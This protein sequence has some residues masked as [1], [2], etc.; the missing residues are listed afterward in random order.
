MK[1][2]HILIPLLGLAMACS[3]KP[4]PNPI[5]EPEEVITPEAVYNFDTTAF[6][7]KEPFIHI[8]DSGLEGFLVIYGYDTDNQVNGK[9]SR[10]DVNTVSS[11]HLN[12]FLNHS[13]SILIEKHLYFTKRYELNQSGE[14]FQFPARLNNGITVHLPIIDIK[15]ASALKEFH[16]LNS[17]YCDYSSIGKLDF[18]GKNFMD[19]I[20]LITSSQEVEIMGVES[21]NRLSV[22]RNDYVPNS[23]GFPN[24]N[25][26]LGTIRSITELQLFGIDQIIFP[27]KLYSFHL[28]D[29]NMNTLD[30]TLFPE[31]KELFLSEGANIEKVLFNKKLSRIALDFC[32]KIEGLDFNVLESIEYCHINQLQGLKKVDVSKFSTINSFQSKEN[33]SLDSILVNKDQSLTLPD[34]AGYGRFWEKDDW[35]EWVVKE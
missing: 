32:P 3:K 23:T 28:R 9:M 12:Y 27:K 30:L 24:L 2:T 1:I 35:T 18:G 8:S 33:P 4:D 20:R 29:F 17:F 11:L 13:D 25:A 31:V 10:E 19:A 34:N 5:N 22:S 7:T 26:N 16:N 21:V 6:N 15:D 14:V